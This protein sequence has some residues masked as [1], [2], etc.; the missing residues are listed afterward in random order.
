MSLCSS[1]VSEKA[2]E[3]AKL[4][5]QGHR[6]ARGLLPEN[7]VRGFIKAV[8]LGVNTLELDLCITADNKVFVSHEPYISSEICLDSNANMIPEAIASQLNTYRMTYEEVKNYDCGTLMN[9]NFPSQG[10]VRTIK[11]LLS[12]VFQR[13]ENYVKTNKIPLPNYNIEIKSGESTDGI[14]HPS[15]AQFSKLVYKEIDGVINWERV[16]LQSFDFRVLKYIR[17]N[18]P[19]IRLAQLIENNLP[20]KT[21]VDSLGFKPDIYSC[22]F[23]ILTQK[24]IK[25][26]QNDSI[27]VIPWTVNDTEDMLRLTEWGVDGIITDYPNKA[28]EIYLCCS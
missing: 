12:D 10:K 5:I 9:K 18:Y 21:N 16:T 8:E 28:L 24:T 22:H 1:P 14:Y 15:P 19:K 26:I 13:V 4:D 25:E 6:G 23:P 27:Q 3:R 17:K 11:P 20:W 2:K 7:S